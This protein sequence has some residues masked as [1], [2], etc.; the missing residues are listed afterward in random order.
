M[1]QKPLAGALLGALGL[2]VAAAAPAATPHTIH[3]PAMGQLNT[4]ALAQRLGMDPQATLAPGLQLRTARGTLKT[5]E[6]QMFRG[7]P[8]YGRSVVVERDAAGNVRSVEGHLSNGLGFD[9]ASVRP[10]VSGSGAVTALRQHAGLL[11]LGIGTGI[12]AVSDADLQNVK[13]QLYVYAEGSKARLVY[14]TSFFVDRHGHPTRPTAIVDANTG[15][16]IESWEGLT[17]GNGHGKPGGGGGGGGSGTA[18]AANGPG[19]NEKT[20]QYFYG[21]DYPALSVTQSGSTCSMV[22]ADVKTNDMG[23]SRNRATLWTF[24]CPTSSGDGINGAYSPINDAHHF[25]A[26]VHD[27]YNA[28]FGAPPLNMQLVMNVHYSRNYE[29]AFWNGSSMTFGDG[30]STFYPLTALDVTS[31]EI[32]HGFTEQNSG[33]QYSGQSGGMN[34]AFSD[35]AGEAAEYYDRGA[36]DWL[37]GA[38]IMK[39]GTAL[40]W[41]C[42][43]GNDGGS[44]DNAADYYSGLDVHYSSGVYNKAFCTL[45]KSSNWNT[46]KAFEVFERANALYW[47]ANSTFNAGACGV[48]NAADDYGYSRSDVV[49]AFNAVGVT[50]Q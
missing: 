12:N 31:H 38:D 41:M 43:P 32:S 42:T 39:R 13:H 10:R 1:M 15:A 22:N 49:A 50:C 4:S 37:V 18:A 20:G 17:T 26:V 46:H 9:L 24:T 45:A 47:T 2:A 14:L 3:A 34:E 30:A 11:P 25:G 6:H 35:M 19:G 7:V 40:R 16:I 21:T 23:Q 5:R 28:W 33:L 27:M 48:E 44:I 8:V 36:N 29:N